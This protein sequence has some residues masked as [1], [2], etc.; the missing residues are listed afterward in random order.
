MNFTRFTGKSLPDAEYQKQSYRAVP[1]VQDAQQ[2]IYHPCKHFVYLCEPKGKL[3][4]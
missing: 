2:P 4:V 1:D 3:P